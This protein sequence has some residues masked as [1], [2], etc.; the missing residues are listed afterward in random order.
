VGLAWMW[1]VLG[2]VPAV[3]DDAVSIQTLIPFAETA[4]I[5][6][7]IRQDCGL[8]TKLSRAIGE[9][10]EKKEIALVRVGNLGKEGGNLSLELRITDAI[11]AAGGVFPASSLSI[12]GVLKKDSKVV[13]TFVATRFAK[14]SLFPFVRSECAILSVAVDLLAKDVVKWLNAPRLDSRIGDSR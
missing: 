11:E 3:A 4:D 10:A 2:D 9:R 6:D 7:R 13:G 8:S 5:R 1:V 14:A 12:D